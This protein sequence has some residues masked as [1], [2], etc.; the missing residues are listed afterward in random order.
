MVVP[1][2]KRGYLR[3]LGIV[4]GGILA[5]YLVVRGVAELFTI[6]CR[7]PVTWDQLDAGFAS[8][9]GPPPLPVM[10]PP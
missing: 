6:D 4:L 8:D 5:L 10:G 2:M 1:S 9:M 3:W 7:L